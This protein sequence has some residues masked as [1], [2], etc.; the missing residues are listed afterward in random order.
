MSYR[1]KWTKEDVD[2]LIDKYGN[3]DNAVISVSLG[4]TL[5]SVR[6][7]AYKLNLYKNNHTVSK[8]GVPKSHVGIMF[9]KYKERLLCFSDFELADIFNSNPSAIKALRQYNNIKRR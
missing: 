9:E 1:E 4:K 6:C 8:L 3:T 7:K 2:F 5:N